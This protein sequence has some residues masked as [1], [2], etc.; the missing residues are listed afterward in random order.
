MNFN[1][2]LLQ[3]YDLGGIDISTLQGENNL[4]ASTGDTTAQYI[5]ILEDDK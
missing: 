3:G 1:E 5:K 4:F 2:R